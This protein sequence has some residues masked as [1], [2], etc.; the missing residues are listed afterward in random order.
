MDFSCPSHANNHA[1]NVYNKTPN[2][3]EFTRQMQILCQQYNMVPQPY[4][5]Q[6]HNYGHFGT[7]HNYNNNQYQ[8]SNNEYRTGKIIN[9]EYRN[10]QFHT[11]MNKGIPN[12]VSQYKERGNSGH[13]P[14]SQLKNNVEK[15]RN[16]RKNKLVLF[17][18]GIS[19]NTNHE[20]NLNRVPL[21]R[22][23]ENECNKNTEEEI[24]KK[25]KTY[26]NDRKNKRDE[27]VTNNKQMIKT[28]EKFNKSKQN[29]LS[30]IFE[31]DSLNEYSDYR[32]LYKEIRLHKP[33]IHVKSAFI[34]KIN[35]LVI[36]TDQKRDKDSIETPWPSDAFKTGIKLKE[37]KIR[38]FVAIKGVSR[39]HSPDTIL[40]SIRNDYKAIDAIRK[41]KRNH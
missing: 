25:K 14:I 40:E 33:N 20:Q 34:N 11:P 7:T 23:N 12:R 41:I 10:R 28:N 6:N 24:K 22:N 30:S 3:E 27:N 17:K 39:R 21:E 32:N 29:E 31:G 13:T 38:H 26:Q 15:D 19:Q 2:Q 37:R 8:F 18:T 1:N 4:Y 5:Q 16:E 36:I 35:N 9:D